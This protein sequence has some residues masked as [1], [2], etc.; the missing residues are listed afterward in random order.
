MSNDRIALIICVYYLFSSAPLYD[1]GKIET[2]PIAN[3]D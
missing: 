2:R 3:P 1:P